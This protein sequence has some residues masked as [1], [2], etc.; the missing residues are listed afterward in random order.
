[1][2]RRSTL[3]PVLLVVLGTLACG[4]AERDPPAVTTTDSLGI[5]VRTYHHTTDRLEA[6]GHGLDP[7]LHIGALEGGSP[8]VFG[9]IS[10]LRIT[11]EGGVVV[12]DALA[13][14]VRSFSP[15]GEFLGSLGG[16]GE[17]PGEFSNSLALLRVSGDSVWIW[18]Q[19]LQRISVFAEGGFATSWSTPGE[20]VLSRAVLVG[21]SVFGQTN[22]RFVGLPETGM[23]RPSVLYATLGQ[24][25]SYSTLFELPGHERYL[26]I[27]Q[28]DGQITAVNVFQHPFARGPFL[29]VL[30]SDTEIRV[31]GGP[32]DRM[33][34]REW[35][36][37]GELR[38]IHRYPGLDRPLTD[39]LVERA[40]QRIMDR[41]DGPDPRMRLELAALEA[42]VPEFLPAFDRVWGDDEDR[43]WLRRSAEDGVEEWLVLAVEDL[44]PMARIVLPTG[45]ALLHVR[46]GLLGG[47]WLDGMDV[48]H[49]RVYRLQAEG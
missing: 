39:A 8:D 23:S 6:W 36:D 45:F 31:V 25:G 32:N 40:R 30:T 20:L 43:L 13:G 5:P 17:G 1:M 7:V 24:D 22:M 4:D 42:E 15:S 3:P 35:R 48:S 34:L 47:R 21:G 14:E 38:A 41:F 46:D 16:F 2:K 19:R 49:V 12:G 9:R 37:T 44:R 33:V 27:Q 10:S 11:P 18:D 26:D 28:A 29:G